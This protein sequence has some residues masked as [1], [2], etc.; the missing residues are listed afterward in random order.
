MERFRGVS[1]F[2]FMER[3][4]TDEDCLEYIAYHK[5]LNGFTCP[6]CGD[7]NCWEGQKPYTKVCKSCRKIESATSNTHFHGVKIGLRKAF[8]IIFEMSTTTKSVSANQISKR[9]NLN[10]QSAWLFMRKVRDIMASSE[11]YPMTG[12]II[13]DEIVVGGYEE[14]VAGRNKESKKTKVAIALEIHNNIGVKRGYALI[15]DSYA[16]TDLRKIFDKHID[17]SAEILTDKWRGYAPLKKDYNITQEK[18]T[19][20]N[21][22]PMNRYV[23]GLKSWLRGIH[24]HVDSYHL[25]AYLDEYSY[26][27]NRHFSKDC[28]FDET[29]E[30][31]V[32]G[33][34]TNKKSLSKPE[35]QTY[36]QRKERI[37]IELMAKGEFG[38]VA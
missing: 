24:H 38:E 21:F 1:T 14:G 9:V 31:M 4:K 8:W 19:K 20:K 7:T 27:F 3:F 12:S 18:S 33:G 23:Q 16:N 29:I 11:L 10:Y 25:Q 13:V 34:V 28:I 37:T 15:I 17:K 32:L 26:R 5:W 36:E 35:L 6:R 2:D 30:R 22:I